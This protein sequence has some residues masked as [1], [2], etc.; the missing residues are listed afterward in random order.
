VRRGTVRGPAGGIIAAPR[1]GR[2][3]AVASIARLKNRIHQV[4]PRPGTRPS[5]VASQASRPGPA[6]GATSP[7]AM[8]SGSSHDCTPVRH[9]MGKRAAICVPT[10]IYR[11]AGSS[12]IVM[13]LSNSPRPTITMLP[14]TTAMTKNRACR[15]SS[16]NSSNAGILNSGTGPPREKGR[17][18][19]RPFTEVK[20]GV[21]TGARRRQLAACFL[22]AGNAGTCEPSLYLLPGFACEVGLLPGHGATQSLRGCAAGGNPRN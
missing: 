4:V 16:R 17:C 14:V 21:V 5:K 2:T 13:G 18:H 12:A 6:P 8:S 11:R 9:L 7:A 3:Y 1:E 10:A 15:G 22:P 19:Q 20:R